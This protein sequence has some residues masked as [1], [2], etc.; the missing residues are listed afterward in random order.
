MS[1]R[2]QRWI[3]IGLA[4]AAGTVAVLLG[5]PVYMVTLLFVLLVCP[6]MMFTMMR[7]D[8]HQSRGRPNESSAESL[9]RDTSR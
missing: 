9:P 1:T 5:A 3:W 2:T 8:R 4:F 6:A 7:G